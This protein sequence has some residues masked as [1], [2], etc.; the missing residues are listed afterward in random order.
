MDAE[1]VFEIFFRKFHR[2]HS[3]LTIL[4]FDRNRQF[5]KILWK[6]ICKNFGIE[7]KLST[8]YQPQIDG[9]IKRMNQTV[10][11]FLRIYIDFYQRN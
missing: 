4:I 5:V 10:T 6:N 7:R 8:I 2:Q 11:I 1:T 3:L 9:A